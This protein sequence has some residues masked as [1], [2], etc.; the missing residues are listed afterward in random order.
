MFEQNRSAGVSIDTSIDSSFNMTL[1][2]LLL[3]FDILSDQITIS[4]HSAIFS[5]FLSTM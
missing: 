2:I 4:H 5:T 3:C 1:M